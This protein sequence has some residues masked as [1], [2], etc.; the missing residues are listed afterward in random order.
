MHQDGTEL[1]VHL[2]IMTV[3]PLSVTDLLLWSDV[4]L[5]AK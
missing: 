1:V 5:S 4:D 3:S 2:T